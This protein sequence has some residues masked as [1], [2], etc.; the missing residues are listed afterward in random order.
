MAN[1]FVW[2]WSTFSPGGRVV[3]SWAKISAACRSGA[4]RFKSLVAGTFLLPQKEPEGFTFFLNTIHQ[5]GSCLPISTSDQKLLQVP[6]SSHPTLSGWY[7]HTQIQC[8][9]EAV[10]LL[11]THKQRKLLCAIV[12]SCCGFFSTNSLKS[13]TRT[14]RRGSAIKQESL[15]LDSGWRDLVCE[16]CRPSRFRSPRG[17][18]QKTCM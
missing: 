15:D 7:L 2:C 9:G 3:S 18:L 8:C 1:Y 10:V 14:P 16:G 11:H 4:A 5:L 13:L 6:F 17:A 12:M